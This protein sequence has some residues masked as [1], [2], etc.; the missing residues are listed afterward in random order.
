MVGANGGGGELPLNELFPAWPDFLAASAPV[1]LPSQEPALSSLQ[2]L[3]CRLQGL[4]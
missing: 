2:R 4:N 1:E 3:A